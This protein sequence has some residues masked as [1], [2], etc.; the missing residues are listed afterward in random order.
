[1]PLPLDGLRILTI[2]QFGAGPY[3][4][5]F[6]ADM[7]AEV[8]KIENPAVGG[9]FS[10][11][12]GPFFLGDYDS[13]FYQCFS[14][15]KRSLTL[16]LKCEDGQK[17]L[18]DLVR[19]SDAIVNNMRGNLPAKLGLDYPS[20]KAINA[21]IVCGHISAYGRDN[22]RADW[23]GYDYLM[24]SEAGFLSVTGEPEG[25]PT[26]FGLSMV[27]FITGTMLVFAVTS[28]ILSVKQGNPGRDVDVSLFD[29]ALHQLTYPG[30]W[31]LN[32][33]HVTG[34]ITRGAHP[35]VT[36][37]QLLKSQDGWIFV[38][39]QNPKFWDLML[40]GIGRQDL[41]E[42]AR[43]VDLE[44][45]LAHRDELTVI[46]DNIFETKTTKEWIEIYKGKI[47]VAP[48]HD[49]PQALDNPF[50]EEVSMIN[51]VPHP[52]R[53]DM[54]AL[55]N[56]IRLDGERLEA[57]YAPKLGQDTE[58]ILSELG[59]DAAKIEALSKEGVV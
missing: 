26:R 46:L 40:E 51:T 14:L 18:H 2:E 50:V 25:P 3:G 34:R 17:I 11:S 10:R 42:D 53:P 38:M 55:A 33:G 35:S 4:A 24:Q 32:E 29:A 58:D 54:R 37:S 49:M 28:A 21:N 57:K 1:M 16:D 27:D 9:D 6:L 13:L 44:A 48:V 45:R 43:F 22:S 36:P 8:I 59:Y 52:D 7:G 47:P 23:P 30:M 56:P 41:A 39:C 20:L 19:S 12:T 31:Y 5:M 15:N